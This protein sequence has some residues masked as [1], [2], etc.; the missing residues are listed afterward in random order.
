MK[1]LRVWTQ[2]YITAS[3]TIAGK[4]KPNKKML[5]T[6]LEKIQLNSFFIEIK[7]F[8]FI[9]LLLF[10]IL[11]GSMYFILRPKFILD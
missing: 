4:K 7:H 10:V 1:W 3:L 9:I 8:A 2:V 6:G 11:I 5:H